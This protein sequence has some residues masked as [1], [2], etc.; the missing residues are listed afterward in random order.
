MQLYNTE[1][2]GQVRLAS[3]SLFQNKV[4]VHYQ[5]LANE[6]HSHKLTGLQGPI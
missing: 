2:G 1:R 4:Y 3:E 6:L 5:A